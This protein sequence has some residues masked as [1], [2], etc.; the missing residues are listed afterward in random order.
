MFRSFSNRM[1]GGVCGGLGARTP[2][3]AW[4]WRVGFALLTPLSGGV[5]A[6]VY[7][8]LWWLLPLDSPVRPVSGGVLR[9]L[10]ALLLSVGL[11]AGWFARGA[12]LD[13][14]GFPAYP[15]LLLLVVGLV[16][17]GKQFTRGNVVLALLSVLVPLL[18]LLGEAG[19][20]ASGLYD[21][22][23]RS[24]PVLLVFLGFSVLLRYRTRFSGVLALLLSAL[25]VMGLGLWAFSSREGDQRTEQQL[26]IAIP[27]EDEHDRASI[28]PE[29]TT[30]QVNLATLDTDVQLS[31]RTGD[32]RRITGEFVGGNNSVVLLDYREEGSIATFTLEETQ[33][34]AFP[35]LEDV[36][37]ATLR[38]ELPPDIALGLAFVGQAGAVS[39]DLAL[40]NLERLDLTLLEGDAFVTLP[41]Y[42]PLSPSVQ[43]RPGQW[44]V[45]QGDLTVTVPESVGLRMLLSRDRN[46]EPS[47]G[48]TYDDLQYRVELAGDD[49]LLISRRYDSL[50]LQRTVRVDVLN[51]T[52]RILAAE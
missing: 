3:N 36:G 6:V 17:A 18:L 10:L 22:V 44:S 47:P 13:A 16:F 30:L 29:I 42:Q 9:G 43:E 5:A 19:A 35:R 28:S 2:L 12:L 52:L 48:S 46:T 26:A 37:R 51:G 34:S 31:I 7:V 24:W 11:L 4:V 15:W 45:V 14:L 23:Q 50:D 25:L 49:F 40:L 41:Q 32:E 20:L 39:A 21:L 27:N 33:R 1:L 38:L 8:L